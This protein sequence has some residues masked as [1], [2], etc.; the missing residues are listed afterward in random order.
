MKKVLI[1]IAGFL[2]LTLASCKKN[3]IEKIPTSTVSVDVLYKTDKDFQD[4]VTGCYNVLQT[5]YQNFWVFGDLPADDIEEDIPNHFEHIAFE[6]FTVNDRT[7]TLETTWM[8]YYNL[9]NR[10]NTLLSKIESTDTAVVKNKNRH[11]GEAKFM[12]AL[13]YF[14]LVRIY[15][16]VPIVTGNLTIEQSYKTG[17]EK[18]DKIYD[19]IIVKDLLDA[20]AR[21]PVKY[22]GADIGRVTKGAVKAILGKVYLT[23]KDF[24]KAETKLQEVTTLGYALLPN[25]KDLFDYTKNEH[26]NEYIFDIEYEEGIGEGSNFTHAFVPAWITLTDFYGIKGGQAQSDG[27]LTPGFYAAFDS[28]DI[29]RNISV[30]YGITKNGVFMPIPTTT[31]QASKSYSL[32][33]VTPVASGNDSRANWKVVRYADVLLMYAEALNENGKTDMALDYLKVV[34]VRA[35]LQ[36]YTGLT[37]DDTREK[38]YL[39]RRLELSLEGQRWFDLVRTGRAFTTLQA[40][41]MK[42]YMTIFPIPLSQVQI[43]NNPGIFAQNPG[44]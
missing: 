9:I 17:R 40:A 12:R 35:G 34:R 28:A 4:A 33:Y 42:S 8:N 19:D 15:G 11:I 32:K 41:G 29:R 31:I 36:G 43:I 18:T 5:Q 39:E 16:D 13:A 44:Y 21:L 37:K 25:Y 20:E 38:I 30:Q 22:T 23:R 26:H 7:A 24:V 1:I 3:F 27:A 6:Q 10:A 2:F 14:D